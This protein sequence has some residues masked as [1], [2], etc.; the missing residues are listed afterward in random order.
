MRPGFGVPLDDWRT[1]QLWKIHAQGVLHPGHDPCELNWWILWRRVAGGLSRGHQEELSSVVFPML[2][3]SLQKRA[4]KK[5][6]RPKSQEA[7]EMWRAAASLER[8]GA[9]SRAQLGDALIELIE[10]KQAPKGALWCLGRIGARK[11]LYGPREAV[12]RPS[13][14]ADWAKRLM[15]LGKPSKEEDPTSCLISITRLAGDRQ[16]DLEDDVRREVS[17]FLEKL[18][19]GEETRAALT[20]V[21][22]VDQSGESAAFG[23]NLPAGLRLS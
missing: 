15:K 19:V 20:R 12:V 10:K 7:A 8:I 9:K 22:E 11:L 6:P 3:P 1:R 21:M 4:K 2:I 23:E 18:G 14:A 17:A 16:I 13:T 5:P